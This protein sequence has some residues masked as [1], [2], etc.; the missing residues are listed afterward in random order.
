MGLPRL[1]WLTS[2][3]PLPCRV[4]QVTGWAIVRGLRSGYK[5]P[6]YPCLV[7]RLTYKH[8]RRVSRRPNIIWHGLNRLATQSVQIRFYSARRVKDWLQVLSGDLLR[9]GHERC[10]QL[11]TSQL[12]TFAGAGWLAES[13]T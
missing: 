12:S 10:R 13:A 5:K 7:Q 1:L 6:S 11:L 4:T 2:A 9:S 3:A 8:A